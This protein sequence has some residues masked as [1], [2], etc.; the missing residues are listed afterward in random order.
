MEM[1]GWKGS[2]EVG[3]S[4][5]QMRRGLRGIGRGSHTGGKLRGVGR[6]TV[7]ETRG[8]LGRAHR[9]HMPQPT[10]LGG[11]RTVVRG[12]AGA[13]KKIGTRGA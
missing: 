6:V 11:T 13:E 10:T 9:A 7:I 1:T 8:S 5:L 2:A 4:A 3:K 12:N